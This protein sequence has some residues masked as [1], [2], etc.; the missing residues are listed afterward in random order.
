VTRAYVLGLLAYAVG[1]SAM[2]VARSV[3]V[4]VVSP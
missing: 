1:A 4:I 3:T 2:T